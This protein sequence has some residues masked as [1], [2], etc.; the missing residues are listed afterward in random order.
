MTEPIKNQV[1]GDE[2]GILVNMPEGFAYKLAEIANATVN[3]GT[4]ALKYDWANSHSSLAEMDR[5]RG[6]IN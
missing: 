2:H 4:G 6:Q 5:T 1:T 3:R